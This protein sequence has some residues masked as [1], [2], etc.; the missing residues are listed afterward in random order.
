MAMMRLYNEVMETFPTLSGPRSVWTVGKMSVEPGAPA[1][2]HP[3][4]PAHAITYQQF[5]SEH[6][7]QAPQHGRQ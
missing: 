3:T 1:R 5:A 2:R 4:Q 6:G 7:R